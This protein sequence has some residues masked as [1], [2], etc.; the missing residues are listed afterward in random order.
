MGSPISTGDSP[1]RTT[2]VGSADTGADGGTDAAVD[3]GTDGGPSVVHAAQ[4]RA[5]SGTTMRRTSPRFI[6]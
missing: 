5:R 1:L 3:P 6:A 2:G 4:R